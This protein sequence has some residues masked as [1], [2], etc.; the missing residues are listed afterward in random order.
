M[1]Y[2]HNIIISEFVKQQ[3]NSEE[4]KHALKK[5]VPFDLEKEKLQLKED[6]ATGLNEQHIKILTITLTKERHTNK[7]LEFI[8]ERLSEQQKKLIISQK[9][10]RTDEY[11]HFFI[12]IDQEKWNKEQQILL[13]DHGNCI[14]IKISLAAFP[15][16]KDVALKIVEEIFGEKN[17]I[18]KNAQ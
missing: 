1:K 17:S 6:T 18:F 15:A 11:N 13:V 2:T 5:L 9:D 7:F 8:I 16:K 4:I 3:E 14:H 10:S 12:R